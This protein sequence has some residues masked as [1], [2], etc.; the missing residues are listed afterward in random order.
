VFKKLEHMNVWFPYFKHFAS[1]FKKD[2]KG[3]PPSPSNIPQR[4]DALTKLEEQP[5]PFN[6]MQALSVILL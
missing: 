3:M 1:L 5:S 4:Q 2:A 6:I